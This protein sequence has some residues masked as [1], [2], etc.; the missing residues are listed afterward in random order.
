MGRVVA[1]SEESGC[2]EKVCNRAGLKN[3]QR[4]GNGFLL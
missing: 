1:S 3:A 2:G 4:Q